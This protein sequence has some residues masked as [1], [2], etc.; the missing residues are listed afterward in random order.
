[1]PGHVDEPDGHSPLARGEIVVRGWAFEASSAVAKVELTLDGRPLGRA[2][3]GRTRPDVAANLGQPD[4]E[5]SGFE[6]AVDLSR[7]T[8]IGEA[9]LLVATTT[10]LNGD[11]VELTP[12]ALTFGALA[13]PSSS[14]GAAHRVPAEGATPSQPRRRR[15][16]N[17]RIRVLWH[18][19]S[20]DEGGSQLRLREVIEHLR[21]SGGFEN[22]VVAPGDGPLKHALE[23]AGA[24]VRTIPRPSMDDPE[25]YE[26]QV[27]QFASVA[28]GDVDV[29]VGATL[30]CFQAVEVAERLGLPSVWRIGEAEPIRTVVR[31]LYGDLHPEI[32]QRAERAAA[33][34]S[35]VL[36]TSS[37]AMRV[38]C[39]SG[40]SG[41]F[42][43]V[44]TGTDVAGASA[45]RATRDR[46]AARH[47]LGVAPEERLLVLAATIWPVKGQA[48]L[49]AA[50]AFASPGQRRL[51]C[52]MV[53]EPHGEYAAAISRFVERAG[54]AS[55]V[56]ILPFCKDLRPWWRAADVGVCVSETESLP[57]SVLEAMS[58]GLPI[59]ASRV[60]DLPE[61]VR[62]GV[63]GWLFDPSDL[64]SLVAALG[65]V[66]AVS[67][68]ELRL[69]GEA[70]GRTV[71]RYDRSEVNGRM[72]ELLLAVAGG[73]VPSWLDLRTGDSQTAIC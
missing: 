48:L 35:V 73:S 40:W 3:L 12:V 64:G 50:L 47:A 23:L 66:S 11:R 10:L 18:A 33:V 14:S 63:T 59:L 29:V 25:E 69:L 34:A 24:T 21:G 42:A 43:V 19:R 61:I 31:W 4:A 13:P 27:A 72:A 46:L 54:L 49:A 68:P 39:A 22:T 70:A 41:R 17:R 20:L 58:F 30:T 28:A 56:R 45:Y 6:L 65:E 62:A 1:M 7:I 44:R 15:I 52:A 60:G 57:A 26:A 67:E 51:T 36:F 9:A 53:G 55:A 5:L 37:E 16:R 32:E 2:G 71:Q 38:C 8:G